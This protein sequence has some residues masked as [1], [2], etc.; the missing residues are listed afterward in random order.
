MLVTSIF[1]NLIKY[2]AYIDM[3]INKHIQILGCATVYFGG[4]EPNNYPAQIGSRLP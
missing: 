1:S 2:A 4:Y 3:K